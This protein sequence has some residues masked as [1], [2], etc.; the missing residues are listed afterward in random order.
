MRKQSPRS[1]AGKSAK[2]TGSQLVIYSHLMLNKPE[3]KEN[4]RK[5]KMS[6]I[7]CT[8]KARSPSRVT[9]L[10]CLGQCPRCNTERILDQPWCNLIG[11]L[12]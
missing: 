10:D 7:D 4:G 5:K 2:L 6:L 3:G 8:L 12:N 9:M 1:Q 11:P